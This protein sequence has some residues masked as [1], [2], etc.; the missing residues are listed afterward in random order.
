MYI[1]G[2][3]LGPL[4]S[5]MHPL[6][7]SLHSQM[8]RCCRSALGTRCDS[9]PPPPLVL[10]LHP[11]PAAAAAPP[12]MPAVTPLPHRPEPSARSAGGQGDGEMP[13]NVRLTRSDTH[14][15]QHQLF[16][17]GTMSEHVTL[18]AE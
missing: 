18:C 1:G 11:T 7:P 3:S 2:V 14:P 12:W 6:P 4:K 17:C 13:Q 10:P 8:C 15:A 9:A 5:M 16:I